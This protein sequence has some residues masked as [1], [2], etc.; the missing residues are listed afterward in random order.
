MEPIQI[1]A[2]VLGQVAMPDFC[3]RCFWIKLH[4]QKLPWQI[5]PGIFST[6]DAYTKKIVHQWIDRKEG[7]PKFIDDLGITG[8]MKVP[9]WSKFRTETEFGIILSGAPDDLL[10]CRDDTIHIPD[11]KT[12]KFTETQDKLYP[13]YA[14]QVNGYAKIAMATG[15]NVTGTSLIYMEPQTDEKAVELCGK[16][17][18][19]FTMPFNPHFL[20]VEL[21]IESLDPLLER[22]RKIY[23]SHVPFGREN[24][25]DCIALKQIIGITI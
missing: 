15:L 16:M 22:A 18:K 10:V 6:I 11:Y 19:Y 24:C 25:P 20:P 23:D 5:F 3:P 14:A 17:S 4:T 13:M 2:K 9:H 8:Y 1:S 21:N 12:A 7:R